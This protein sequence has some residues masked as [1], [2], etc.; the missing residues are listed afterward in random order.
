MLAST[1]Y[2]WNKYQT[3]KQTN[4]IYSVHHTAV[5]SEKLINSR[6]HYCKF[7]YHEVNPILLQLNKNENNE[8]LKLL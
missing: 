6:V 8:T 4:F 7:L 2:V 1:I 5:S 3:N